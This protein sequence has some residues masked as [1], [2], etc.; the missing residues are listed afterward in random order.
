MFL[1]LFGKASIFVTFMLAF[2]GFITTGA[3]ANSSIL[4]INVERGSVSEAKVRPGTTLTI[5]TNQSF[6]DIVVGNQEIA[7]I[8]PLSEFSLYIQGKTPGLTT[9]TLYDE[10]KRVLTVIDVKVQVDGNAV[11]SAIRSAVPTSRIT[12]TNVGNRIRLNGVVRSPVDLEKVTEIA[13]QFS[14]EPVIRSISIGAAQQVSIEVRILEASRSV[15]R[16]L[17]V[18]LIGTTN[19]SSVITGDRIS[20]QIVGDPPAPLLPTLS[21]QG[22]VSA[23]LAQSLPFA[24]ILANLL[25][26][27]NVNIDALI[28]ALEDKN[29][30]RSLAQPNLTSVSGEVARF[31]VGGEVPVTSAVNSGGGVAEEV[32]FRPFGVRLEFVPTVLDEQKINLRILTEV[33]DIDPSIT[34]NGNP[35]FTS[36]RAET[37]VELRDG[38]SFSLAGLLQTQNNRAL[39]QFPWI[40]NVPILGSLFRSSAFQKAETE[41]VIIATPRLIRPGAPDEDFFSPLGKT[42]S[43]NDVELF[44]LGLLEVNKDVLRKFKNGEGVVGPYGHIIDLEFDDEFVG[45]K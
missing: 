12:A 28:E 38:Q 14:S 42:K 9:V 4:Q 21:A 30:A 18:N 33:S 22:V 23:G 8:V 26:A 15:G 6:S 25:S 19:N 36:R 16:N 20:Q 27:G 3:Y 39:Q 10:E 29:V 13:Q 2:S 37:V 44:A 5:E 17:G 43:S 35:G 31:H 24:T 40:G 34:V 1:Q 32:D 7:D 41:L 45:K 11:E